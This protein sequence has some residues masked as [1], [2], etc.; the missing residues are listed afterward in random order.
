M[1]KLV[2]HVFIIGAMLAGCKSDEEGRPAVSVSASDFCTAT[3]EV[4]CY[5]MFKCCTGAQIEEFL[6]LVQTT[7]RS[8]CERDVKLLCQ[9]NMAEIL[10]SMEWGRVSVDTAAWNSCLQALLAPEAVCFVVRESAPWREACNLEKFHGTVGSGL[11]CQNQYECIPN[12]YCGVDQKCHPYKGLNEVCAT[13]DCSSGLY[14][15]YDTYT[16][17]GLKSQGQVCDYS[18]QCAESLFCETPTTGNPTCQALRSTGMNCTDSAQCTS[19]YCIP[20]MCDDGNSCFTE[21]DCSGTCEGSGDYCYGT[22][23]C[24]AIC[25]ISGS[26]CYDNPDCTQTGDNCNTHPVCERTCMGQPV[27]GQVVG[28]IDYCEDA[29]ESLL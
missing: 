13:G 27:C 14:C 5:N 15:D 16:C 12:N 21:E 29:L 6:G 4:A 17:L 23:T 2:V 19:D 10:W 24:S 9:E 8:A 25:V 20:G 11:S 18:S 7:D 26:Y 3:A 1:R 22:G 28:V